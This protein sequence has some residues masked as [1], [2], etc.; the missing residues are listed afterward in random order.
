MARMVKPKPLGPL[1]MMM[2]G[3][4]L[5]M[6]GEMSLQGLALRLLA[7]LLPPG[8]W[9]AMPATPPAIAPAMSS[10]GI[11]RLRPVALLDLTILDLTLSQLVTRGLGTPGS[12]DI[13]DCWAE[14]ECAMRLGRLAG[15]D[16]FNAATMASVSSAEMENLGRES[17]CLRLL[18]S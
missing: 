12:H 14:D 13:L 17:L 2:G 15:L 3:L 1:L 4:R 9:T 5:L 10:V 18:W 7:V 6:S 8:D 16:L 11:M